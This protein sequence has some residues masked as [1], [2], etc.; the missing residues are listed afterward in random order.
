MS[1][2]LITCLTVTFFALQHLRLF[3]KKIIF[4]GVTSSQ[5]R[6]LFL[7]FKER[8]RAEWQRKAARAAL[9]NTRRAL[10]DK[11]IWDENLCRV[12]VWKGK[13]NNYTHHC[14][15][16]DGAMRRISEGKQ[17]LFLGVYCE[18]TDQDWVS[19][20]RMKGRSWMSMTTERGREIKM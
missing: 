5:C 2:R 13:K 20:L 19:Q 17:F 8:A 18:Y 3:A 9:K 10:N 11:H 15:G 1:V 12:N 6:E 14:S 4:A 16:G 7:H